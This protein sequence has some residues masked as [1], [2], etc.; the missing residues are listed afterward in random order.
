MMMA[1][2]LTDSE[3][4]VD[5]KSGCQGQIGVTLSGPS[6]T[7]AGRALTQPVTDLDFLP[8]PGLRRVIFY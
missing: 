4:R 2:A 3:P 8:R 6:S 1:A 5:S 7:Q